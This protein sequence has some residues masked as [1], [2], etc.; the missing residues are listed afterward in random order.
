VDGRQAGGRLRRAGL[1]MSPR[2][3]RTTRRLPRETVDY[4][5]RVGMDGQGRPSYGT[6]QSLEANVLEYDATRY[7]E[8]SQFIIA[9]DGS[10]V[11]TPVTLYVPGTVDPEDVPPEESRIT[12]G[13]G[14][15]FIIAE[16]VVVSGLR[17]ARTQPDHYRL[18]CRRE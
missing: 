14:R 17:R 18:R 9:R 2:V 12:L 6:V 3:L 16:R 5:T 1:R 4:Q 7:H 11:M 15:Q 8:G 13:D 10:R